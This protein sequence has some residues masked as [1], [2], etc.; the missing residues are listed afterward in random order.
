MA[1]YYSNYTYSVLYY[2]IIVGTMSHNVL[3]VTHLVR[4]VVP[5]QVAFSTLQPELFYETI[6]VLTFAYI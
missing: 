5:F 2:D 6:S 3:L 1:L 4:V